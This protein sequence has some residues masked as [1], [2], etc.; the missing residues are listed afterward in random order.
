M[1]L[2][3]S[4][5]D[6]TYTQLRACSWMRE[7]WDW[8]AAASHLQPQCFTCFWLVFPKAPWA[9]ASAGGKS[10]GR[11]FQTTQP[12]PVHLHLSL[13]PWAGGRGEDLTKGPLAIPESS[14]VCFTLCPVPQ[15]FPPPGMPTA[16]TLCTSANLH[17]SFR[18]LLNYQ[19]LYEDFPLFEGVLTTSFCML[20]T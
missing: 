1:G 10:K 15:L 9:V 11:Q 2:L 19:F 16:L 18:N 3:V 14:I 20:L 6:I 13:C 17:I 7:A 5:S 12:I 4:V 8:R